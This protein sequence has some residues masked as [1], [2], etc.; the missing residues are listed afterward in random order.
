[1][2]ETLKKLWYQLCLFH[3]KGRV[4][5]AIPPNSTIENILPEGDNSSIKVF[6]EYESKDVSLND[7]TLESCLFKA[8]E[9]ILIDMP[10][11]GF[12][13]SEKPQLKQIANS[14]TDHNEQS[15]KTEQDV[16]VDKLVSLTIDSIRYFDQLRSQMP[17]EDLK[18]MLDEVSGNLIDNLVLSGCTPINEEPGTYDMA[19][20][21]LVPF[22]T[23]ADG[24]QYQTIKR[25]GIEYKGEVKLLAIV[26]L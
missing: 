25:A 26:E 15:T 16:D 12:V 1:M 9:S 10:N 7:T 23:V 14:E 19:R 6:D 2:K 17:T 8:S 20:H 4:E 22:Q 3:R 24:T 21:Q 5:E 18:T 11:I 13:E